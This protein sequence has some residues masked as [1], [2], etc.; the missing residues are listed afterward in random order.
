[1]PDKT[2]PQG[3]D[4]S[5]RKR[6]FVTHPH[7]PAMRER[8]VEESILLLSVV[9]WFFLASV[10]GIL[11]GFST[12]LFLKFLEWGIVT[13]GSYRYSFLLLP[14]AFMVSVILVRMAPEA[15]G[16]GTE[17]V[18]EAVH[19]R[20]GKIN[21]FV[22][23]VKLLATVIT[24]SIG[25]SAGKEG[26]CAQIGAGLS[27]L[28]SDI[29]RFN[30]EDR[31]RLVICGISAGF[32][33][34]F[35][36]PIAG[37]IFG[38]EVLFMG[39]LSYRVLFPSFVAGIVGYQ[40]S[41]A[42]GVT[43]F[44]AP[45]ATVPPFSG[46]FFVQICIAGVFFGLMAVLLIEALRYFEAIRRRGGLSWISW[47]LLGGGSLIAVSLIFGRSYLGLG[48]ETLEGAVQ[49]EEVSVLASFLKILTTS[50]TLAFGG[51]GG[52]VTPVFFVG[53]TSGSLFGQVLGLD[54][55]LFSSI[56]MTSLL[57]G[58]ANTPIS[59]SIMALELFGPAVGPY[60]ALACIIAFLMAG[61]RSV[62]PSQILAVSKSTSLLVESGQKMEEIS[63]VH[64]EPRSRSLIG[65]ILWGARKVRTM[66]GE[67][68]GE[69]EE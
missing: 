40:V 2:P 43:Y 58:A 52:I 33:T 54:R 60:A 7:S 9:K 49:G 55:A 37:A 67:K 8:V 66:T 42:L 1:M 15:A 34:V 46:V 38:V 32:A 48:L 25:G 63:G 4:S 5:R 59:A 20:S 29:F 56:G 3:P 69:K 51:S 27:S 45:L 26:P 19:L 53:A 18:I 36:T 13:A 57:A 64:F 47:S 21:P 10:V 65:S 62:Y 35:G 41:T 28:F 12:V 11:V 61:H 17:K 23:P 30:N 68:K 50:I 16:H 39:S 24:I 22:V 6:Y 31:R 44:H 14:F